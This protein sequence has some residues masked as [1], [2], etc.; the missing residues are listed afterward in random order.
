MYIIRFL[1]RKKTFILFLHF[2]FQEKEKRPLFNFW[3]GLQ[4][5][6]TPYYYQ[7]QMNSL[8]VTSYFK[9]LLKSVKGT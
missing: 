6:H 7:F 4:R 1:T 8:E 3:D 2:I 5:E 9:L